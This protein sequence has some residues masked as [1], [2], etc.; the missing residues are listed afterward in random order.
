M[1]NLQIKKQNQKGKLRILLSQNPKKMTIKTKKNEELI[2]IICLNH[3]NKKTKVDVKIDVNQNS[4]AQVIILVL[5][6]GDSQIVLK[7]QQIHQKKYG[8]SDLLCK[9]VINDKSQFSFKGHI[10]IGTMGAES[11]AYQRNDNLLLSEQAQADSEPKLEIQTNKVFCTHAV[12]TS[13]LDSGQ[14]F[15]LQ[16]RGLSETEANEILIKGFFQA[17]LDKLLTIGFSLR[18]LKS[19]RKTLYQYLL[20]S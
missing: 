2:Q 13:Y 7:T 3:R 6:K 8:Y 1:S 20:I 17:A 9:A 14:R 11:H 4:R 19:I 18:E 15:Y 16:S 5:L 10:N 12:T